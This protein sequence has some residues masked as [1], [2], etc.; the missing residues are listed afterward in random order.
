MPP[1]RLLVTN[2]K[3]PKE[4]SK[5][6]AGVRVLHDALPAV[7]RPVIAAVDA[8]S[9]ECLRGIDEDA[10][11][12][13]AAVAEWRKQVAAASAGGA[14]G[15]AGG[16]PS[17]PLPLDQIPGFRGLGLSDPDDASAGG[18]SLSAPP[19]APQPPA[20]SSASTGVPAGAPAPAPAPLVLPEISD[21]LYARLRQLIRINHALLNG[22]GVGHAALDG[23]VA[24][25]A[26]AGFA[27]KLTGAGGGGCALTLLPPHR[28]V[29]AAAPGAGAVA[30]SAAAEEDEDAASAAAAK[31]LVAGFRAQG[32]D[33]FE[34]RLG[35]DGVLLRRV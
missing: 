15:G 7:V 35:G 27:A 11:W 20:T 13:A 29:V 2:T 33:C 16:V 31:A 23:V 32:Y 22:L 17:P 6:V 26:S 14:A 9:E 10:A 1:L 21:A 28:R 3:V 34:T 25:A 12:R 8:I 24:A 19:S 30:E 18:S 4:T 5:L